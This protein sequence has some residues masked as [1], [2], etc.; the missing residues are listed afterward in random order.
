MSCW[1]LNRL[2]EKPESTEYTKYSSVA[3]RTLQQ[4]LVDPGTSTSDDVIVAVMAFATYAVSRYIR[5]SIIERPNQ[6]SVVSD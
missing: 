3:L 5:Q 6:L 2:R 4:R 1:H